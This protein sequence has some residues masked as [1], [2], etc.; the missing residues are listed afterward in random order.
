MPIAIMTEVGKS[1]SS[2]NMVILPLNAGSLRSC[3]LVI[4]R[5]VSLGL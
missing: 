4:S 1:V 3:Q 2:P 5:L